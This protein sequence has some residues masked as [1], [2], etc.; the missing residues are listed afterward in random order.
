MAGKKNIMNAIKRAVSPK[1]QRCFPSNSVQSSIVVSST[2]LTE[3]ICSRLRGDNLQ[4]FA[5]MFAEAIKNDRHA[6]VILFE[7]VYS[8]LGYER[9]DV[10]VRQL[11]KLFPEITACFENLHPKVEVSPGA[12][13]P[14]KDTYLISVRQFE[15]LMLAAKTEEGPL[16]REIMLDVKDAVQDF[17]KIEMEASARLAQQQLEKQTSKRQDVWSLTRNA[18][19]WRLP[20]RIC[21]RRWRPRRSDARR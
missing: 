14:S 6:K 3:F 4:L 16:A 2:P 15:T 7:N 9:Y 13:G 1:P 21:K 20:K 17:M 5:L 12:R 18:N 8:F 10:A 11:K 19:N